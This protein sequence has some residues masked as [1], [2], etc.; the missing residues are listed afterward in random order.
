MTNYFLVLLIILSTSCNQCAKKEITNF[1]N[2]VAKELYGWGLH[3]EVV[4]S[5]VENTINI[6][7]HFLKNDSNSLNSYFLDEESNN[8]VIAML[9][10]TFYEKLKNY[11]D[12]AYSLSFEDKKDMA[13]MIVLINNTKLNV[14]RTQFENT[15]KF[16]DFVK[17]AFE[18]VQSVDIVRANAWLEYLRDKPEVFDFKGSFWKLLYNFT[19][20]CD[21]PEEKIND[22]Y[23][24]IAFTGLIAD[25]DNPKE[26]DINQENLKYFIKSCGFD[27][28][29]IYLSLPD[30]K[31]VLIEK[32]VK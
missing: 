19:V 12:I 28:E 21:K 26:D 17:Y 3:N 16:Y 31:K 2:E 23:L 29:L 20:A 27:T 32:Y 25:P 22:I 14:T 4:V 13:P 18:H 5:E 1:E 24:F 8:L 9:N 30:L 6:T 10:Q 15:P 7:I 11:K